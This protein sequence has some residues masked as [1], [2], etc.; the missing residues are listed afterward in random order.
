MTKLANKKN[1][2]DEGK[3][4]FYPAL[5]YY[6]FLLRESKK[7]AQQNKNVQHEKQFKKDL[8]IFAK[9]HAHG[10]STKR[11]LNNL[12]ALM[13][14]IILFSKIFHP[15]IIEVEKLQSF[16]TLPQAKREFC[17]KSITPG[18][19]YAVLRLK[20]NTSAPCEDGIM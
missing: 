3:N 11:K 6:N 18:N 12:L 2:S 8:C 4:N 15:K 1:A 20:N 17:S 16:P 13:Q 19:I 14:L 9:K 7:K 10:Q 5:R